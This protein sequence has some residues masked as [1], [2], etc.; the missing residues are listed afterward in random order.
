M[1]DKT[2]NDIDWGIKKLDD[3]LLSHSEQC[4]SSKEVDLYEESNLNEIE[5]KMSVSSKGSTNSGG[6]S[7]DFIPE[8]RKSKKDMPSNFI[9]KEMS[10]AMEEWIRKQSPYGSLKT[11]KLIHLIVKSNDDLWQE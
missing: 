8:I 1:I 7:N 5:R 2:K 3:F 9:F 11:W 4:H 10:E 6:H